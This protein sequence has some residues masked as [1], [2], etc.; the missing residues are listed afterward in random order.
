MTNTELNEKMIIWKP[1][2]LTTSSM[3][4]LLHTS[5]KV[6]LVYKLF[7][8]AIENLIYVYKEGLDLFL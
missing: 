5:I 7:L 4:V 3:I 8:I 1:V 2:G 6:N